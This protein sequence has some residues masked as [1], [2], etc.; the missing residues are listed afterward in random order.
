MIIY[1][2]ALIL[3]NIIVNFFILYITAQTLKIKVS[4]IRLLISSFIGSLYILCY[5]YNSLNFLLA[6]PWKIII[7]IIMVSIA[8]KR[9]E[10]I[11]ILKSS[12]IFILYS[13]LIAG[14][15]IFIEFNKNTY[16]LF[17]FT[18]IQVTYK[19]L[20]ASIMIAYIFINK[21]VIFV[22]ERRC[23]DNLIFEVEIIND[24]K[25]NKVKA[26]L[27]TGNELR[28][29]ATNLPVMLIEKSF[30]GEIHLE[31]KEKF[32]IPYKVINGYSGKLIGFKPDYINIH[33]SEKKVETKDVIIAFCDNKLSN[34]N[35]Y[36]ALLSRGI[37]E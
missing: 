19:Q 31:D 8:Y 13:M 20:L 34:L 33:L 36:N 15:C 1:L 7:A 26:F 6:L 32:Y 37:I 30:F 18:T 10:K 12:A 11:F 16:D 17:N 28:E 24:H 5:I 14:L 2:D 22:K 4:I 21:L 27:D 25:I 29:P 3:E 35:D 9:K 23:L